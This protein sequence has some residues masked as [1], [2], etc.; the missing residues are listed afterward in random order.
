MAA[1]QGI[2]SFNI[3]SAAN[4][5]NPNAAGVGTGE[6]GQFLNDALS[7]VKATD[8]EDKIA[9][10]ELL[11]GESPDLHTA[12]LAGE[13]AELMLRLTTQM[14]NKVIDAYNEVM[15]MQV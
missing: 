9:G 1:I 4:Q 11:A 3:G 5:I 8:A 15:R 6:F 14:R 7:G 12:V 2:N 13:K 10:L